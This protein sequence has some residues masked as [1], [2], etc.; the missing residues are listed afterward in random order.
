MQPGFEGVHI[1]MA[2]NLK[3]LEMSRSTGVEIDLDGGFFPEYLRD[4]LIK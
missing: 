3:F 1:N 2:A 4:A